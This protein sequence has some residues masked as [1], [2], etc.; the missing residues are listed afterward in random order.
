VVNRELDTARALASEAG[1]LIARALGQPTTVARKSPVNLV[2]EVDH[3][4]EALIVS[5]LQ[6]AFPDD[7]VVAEESAPKAAEGQRCWYVDPIDGTTN[8]VHGLP[9]CAVSIALSVGGSVE[10]AVVNDPCKAELF[11]ARRGY[12]SKLNGQAISVSSTLALSDALLGGG[13]PYDRRE[14]RDF[15]SD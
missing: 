9:Q 12:G 3:A 8:F 1:D 11:E 14:N 2:T 4:A 13:F 15:Y 7:V 5:G 6:R 10:V